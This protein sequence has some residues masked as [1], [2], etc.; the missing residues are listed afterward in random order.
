M[1]EP[2]AGAGVTVVR[3]GDGGGMGGFF[4]SG[5]AHRQRLLDGN[6]DL[7]HG[8]EPLPAGVRLRIPDDPD[9]GDTVVST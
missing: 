5:P 7:A 2:P 4:Y 1:P 6:Q 3:G 9:R 8:G